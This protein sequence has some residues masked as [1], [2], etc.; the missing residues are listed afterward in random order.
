MVR[1]LLFLDAHGI[2]AGLWTVVQLVPREARVPD[3]D[4]RVRSRFDNQRFRADIR[5]VHHRAT[6]LW[7]CGRRSLV[8]Y[9]NADWPRCIAVEKAPVRVGGDE[10]VRCSF[11]RWSAAGR[12]VYRLK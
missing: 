9:I 11:G 3:F 2:P 4:H 1:Q 5:G 12:R 10:H 7:S 8:R 6:R